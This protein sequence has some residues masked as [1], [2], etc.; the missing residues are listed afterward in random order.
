MLMEYIRN[1]KNEKIGILVADIIDNDVHIAYSI[2]NKKDKFNKQYGKEITTNR[3]NTH[4]TPHIDNVDVSSL[5]LYETLPYKLLQNHRKY[6]NISNIEHFINRCSRY[7]KD[8]KI[9]ICIPKTQG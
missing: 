5:N 2:C 3:M 1:K 8:K 7:F 4:N 9:F 6:C